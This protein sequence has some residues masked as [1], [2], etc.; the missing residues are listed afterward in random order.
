MKGGL[1]I[2]DLKVGIGPIAKLGKMVGVFYVT[3]L[4]QNN[5]Q[6]DACKEGSRPFKFRIGKGEV[7]KAWDLGLEGMKVINVSVL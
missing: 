5:K 3:R 6:V 4:K 7:I 2:Q 1:I